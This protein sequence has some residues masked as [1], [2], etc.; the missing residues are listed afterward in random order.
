MLQAKL[1]NLKEALADLDTPC[2]HYTRPANHS[3]PY[4]VWQED[5]ANFFRGDNRHAEYMLTGTID[6]FS[7]TE[8]D[9]LFDGVI[10]AVNQVDNSTIT[11]NSVQYEDETGLIHY[12]YAF[13]VA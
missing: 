2:Y 6:V 1:M 7:K 3:L 5:G 12:E 9:P 13:T 11:I 10:N 8:F 4:I